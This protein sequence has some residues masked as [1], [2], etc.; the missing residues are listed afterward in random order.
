MGFSSPAPCRVPAFSSGLFGFCVLITAPVRGK[1]SAQHGHEAAS[2]HE[3]PQWIPDPGVLLLDGYPHSRAARRPL[4]SLPRGE[5]YLNP[6]KGRRARPLERG[7]KSSFQVW[8]DLARLTQREGMSI[9]GKEHGVRLTQGKE[10]SAHRGTPLACLPGGEGT[11]I[12]GKGT[13]LVRLTA[14]VDP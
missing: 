4:G 13:G 7:K 8:R 3:N 11:F 9:P 12:P 10:R 5:G 1:V 14:I 6:G 2:G